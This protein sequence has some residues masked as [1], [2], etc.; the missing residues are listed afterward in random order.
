LIAALTPPEKKGE[1][2]APAPEEKKDT[3]EAHDIVSEILSEEKLIELE[4]TLRRSLSTDKGIDFESVKTMLDG[5][6]EEISRAFSG[7][8][9]GNG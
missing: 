1:E 2:A 3:E 6:T 7:Q 9:K 4:E 8:P 5:I